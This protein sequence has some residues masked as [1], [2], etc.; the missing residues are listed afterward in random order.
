MRQEQILHK[1]L[2]R[3]CHDVVLSLQTCSLQTVSIT[4]PCR[5]LASIDV[6]IVSYHYAGLEAAV[7][8]ELGRGIPRRERIRLRSDLS[9]CS[10]KQV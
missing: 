3:Q 5:N 7:M 6:K 9:S 2:T 10:A 4:I 8:E 1:G